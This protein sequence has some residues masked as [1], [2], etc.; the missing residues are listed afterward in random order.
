MAC[1]SIR[2]EKS[3]PKL[4]RIKSRQRAGLFIPTAVIPK[5]FKIQQTLPN[6]IL[7]KWHNDPIQRTP[8]HDCSRLRRDA[9]PTYSRCH[10]CRF[11]TRGKANFA[12]QRHRRIHANFLADTKGSRTPWLRWLFNVKGALGAQHLFYELRPMPGCL[13]QNH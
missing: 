5:H 2:T 6:C 10:R 1:N 13:Q 12:Y 3:N 9:Y 4:Q 7:T 8:N 11:A